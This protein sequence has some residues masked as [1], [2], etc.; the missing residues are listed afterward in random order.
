MLEPKTEIIDGVEFNFIP[1]DPFVVVKLEKKIAPLLLPV[2]G[3]LKLLDISA[4]LED[5]IDLEALSRGLREA[6]SEMPDDEYE[7]LLKSL[8]V[9]VTATAPGSPAASCAAEGSRVFQG[10]TLLLYKVCLAA[11]RFNKF[12]PFALLERGGA[13]AGIASSIARASA[14][15]GSGLKLERSERSKGTSKSSSRSGG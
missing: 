2:L 1:M 13:I 14:T 11:M 4:E 5:A 12:I 15:T 6:I 8:L 3:G 10:N 7:K 9:N